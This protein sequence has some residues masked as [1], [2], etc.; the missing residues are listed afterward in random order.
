MD[1]SAFYIAASTV[2]PLLLI[3]LIATRSFRPGEMNE[4][5]IITLVTFGLPIIGE[6]AAFSFLFFAPV[7][8][9][10]AAPL[11]VATWAGLLSQL[12][13]VAWWVAE[14]LRPDVPSEP[15]STEHAVES[16]AE[17]QP[18]TSKRRSSGTRPKTAG[19]RVPGRS[20][21][22]LFWY[23]AHPGCNY[24]TQATGAPTCP[25]HNTLLRRGRPP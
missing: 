20:I 14:L 11:A 25:F 13:L 4:Q 8:T 18:S 6:V 12:A 5:P 16:P 24:S 2:I 10:A 9:A 3:A 22:P 1:N 23:C 19:A 7:P 17:V 21:E 15:G